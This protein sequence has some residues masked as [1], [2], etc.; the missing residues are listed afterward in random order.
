MQEGRLFRQCTEFNQISL[1]PQGLVLPDCPLH[2]GSVPIKVISPCEVLS[3]SPMPQWTHNSLLRPPFS[4]P[5]RP[6]W[7]ITSTTRWEQTY[8]RHTPGRLMSV[9][10]SVLD[11]IL[12]SYKLNAVLVWVCVCTIYHSLQ[13]CEPVWFS[14]NCMFLIRETDF[15]S[16]FS[17][18]TYRIKFS[19][20]R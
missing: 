3:V 17:G 5:P 8:L 6:L 2:L 7:P 4:L 13:Q 15:H 12:I 10:W 11:I 1:Y 14:D 16:T 20:E 9:A 19:N 18:I